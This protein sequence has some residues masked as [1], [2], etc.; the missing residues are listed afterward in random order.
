LIILDGQNEL[1]TVAQLA[2]QFGL[3]TN[4]LFRAALEQRSPTTQMD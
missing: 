4:G 3:L 1:L 2:N